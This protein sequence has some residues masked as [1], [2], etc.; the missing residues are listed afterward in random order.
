MPRTTIAV[1]GTRF[2]GKTM[3][4]TS[5]LWQL[6]EWETA[7]FRLHDNI[8]IQGF[9]PHNGRLAPADIFPFER[10][11]NALITQH[12]WPTKTKDVQ[13]YSC[14][15]TRSDRRWRSSQQLDLIDLPGERVADAAVVEFDD[16]AEWSDHM[17]EYFENDSQYEA[18]RRFRA[19][20]EASSMDSDTI[21]RQYRHVLAE[22]VRD[23]KPLV[24]PSVFLLDRQG[25]QAP[26]ISS[27]RE[28][29]LADQR[30]AG[31]DAAT[32]F[33]P[34]PSLVR[35]RRPDTV[36]LMRPHYKRYRKKLARPFF[37]HLWKS[38]A[39][40]V[41]IDIPLL[42]RG[43]VAGFND[44]RQTVEDLVGAMV[45]ESHLG[46]RLAR[47][48]KLPSSLKRVA[49][50]ANKADL[51]S[52]EDWKTDRLKLL[53]RQMNNRARELL[54]SV[55][56]QW[57]VCSACVSTRAG[58]KSNTLSGVPL[59]DNPKQLPFDYPVSRL[60]ESW[61]SDWKSG[62]FDFRDVYPEV[63]PNYMYPPKQHHLDEVFDFVAMA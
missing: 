36:K 33:A 50:V 13:R 24:T 20:L 31:L 59:H 22:F 60:P 53:L 45:R 34:L 5:L 47:K 28:A 1:T 21:L 18:G 52:R 40:I 43:D 23:R 4:L 15:Y 11:Q 38:D 39:L 2:S 48:L 58:R 61:P 25:S 42:L 14:G 29:W 26:Q 10:Y 7:D 55:E 41:L 30:F 3:F 37:D 56:S 57:F 6:R 62:D 46:R 8:A 49:F 54:P 63:G 12:E 9:K 51:V 32:Q 35:Q 17:F 44:T 16:F 27:G 19:N